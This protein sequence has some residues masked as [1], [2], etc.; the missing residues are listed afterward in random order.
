VPPR[1]PLALGQGADRPDP[2]RGVFSTMLAREGEVVDL[3]AHLTRLRK[4]V[5]ELYGETLP[6]RLG[7]RVARAVEARPLVRVRVLAVPGPDGVHVSVEASVLA[8]EP[9]PEPV[10][11]APALL[12]GGLGAHKWLDRR[13][14]AELEQ[15]LGAVPLLVDLDGDVLEAAF[16]NVWIVERGA[17]ATPPLDGR[18]LPGTV[19]ARVIAAAR[20]GG[21]EVREESLSLERL[22]AADELLL[23]SAVRGVYPGV[24]EGRTPAFELGARIGAALHERTAPADPRSSPRGVTPPA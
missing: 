6:Q 20:A 12:P 23:T 11:L 17:L 4:S 22:A 10:T 2:E 24:L 19:R 13:L 7:E 1:I 3:D 21:L 8:A 14:L 9:T 16:A 15:R 5:G 18:L